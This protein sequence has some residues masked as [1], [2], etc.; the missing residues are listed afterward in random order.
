MAGRPRL[1]TPRKQSPDL[2]FT[3]RLSRGLFEMKKKNL[4]QSFSESLAESEARPRSSRIRL[5]EA[6][7][8]AQG[9]R[10]HPATDAERS[11]HFLS[12]L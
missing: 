8:R 2:A 7:I 10:Y 1:V 5:A 12:D 6:M 4:S 11:R 3:T 9:L